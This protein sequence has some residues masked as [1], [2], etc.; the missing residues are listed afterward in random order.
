[1]IKNMFTYHNLCLPPGSPISVPKKHFSQC[2]V[3]LSLRLVQ[4]VS[5]QENDNNERCTV[6]Y[7]LSKVGKNGDKIHKALYNRLVSSHINCTKRFQQLLS[8]GVWV[9]MNPYEENIQQGKT[10]VRVSTAG[11]RLLTSDKTAEEIRSKR[12]RKEEKEILEKQ[13][14]KERVEKARTEGPLT[15]LL[16]NLGYVSEK[17]SKSTLK[18]LDE[19]IKLNRIKVHPKLNRD[20]KGNFLVGYIQSSKTKWIKK[21]SVDSS[22]EPKSSNI[23]NPDSQPIIPFLSLSNYSYFDNQPK[24]IH[25]QPFLHKNPSGVL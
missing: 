19:F 8:E 10:I 6:E 22:L 15:Q 4:Q 1:M 2:P 23:E 12:E 20:S 25:N 13:R 3:E 16:I 14:A 9:D 18:E 21:T 24:F 17:K 11:G 5:Q 7:I